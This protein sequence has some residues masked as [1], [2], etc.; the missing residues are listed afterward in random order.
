M[1][2]GHFAFAPTVSKRPFWIA[3]DHHRTDTCQQNRPRELSIS[4]SGLGIGEQQITQHQQ[5]PAALLRFSYSSAQ[6]HQAENDEKDRPGA[7]QRSAASGTVRDHVIFGG[8]AGSP[9]ERT[10][11]ARCSHVA[12]VN[13]TVKTRRQPRLPRPAGSG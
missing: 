10:A 13:G 2:H 9:G 3:Y 6:S 11:P 1:R 5:G 4:P 8:Y 12:H 7:A